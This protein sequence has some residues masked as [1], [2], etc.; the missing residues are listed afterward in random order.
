[1]FALGINRQAISEL[2]SLPFY[3][4]GRRGSL[5]AEESTEHFSFPT[6]A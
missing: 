1:L 4:P 2:G 5:E 3:F 6:F